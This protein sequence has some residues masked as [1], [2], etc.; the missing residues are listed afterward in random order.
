M[1]RNRSQP[2][3]FIL[4]A[5]ILATVSACCL[6][7]TGGLVYL[8][9]Q[10]DTDPE[11]YERMMA[12]T[13]GVRSE[14]AYT[15]TEADEA[16]VVAV[17]LD[18]AAV[19]DAQA[20]LLW[21]NEQW[22]GHIDL[23][24]LL[25][26]HS[27]ESAGGTNMGDSPGLASAM[28]NTN[29]NPDD[30]YAA[31]QNLLA[32]WKQ[33]NVRAL[34][35][36]AAEYIL[37]DH[38]DW[39]GHASAGELGAGGFIPTTAWRICQVALQTS[40]DPVV[41][42]CDFWNQRVMF[43]AMAYE[44][45]RMGYYPEATTE[46]RVNALYGWNHSESYR[47]QLVSTAD[48]YS[49]YGLSGFNLQTSMLFGSPGEYAFAKAMTI[50]FFQ[51]LGLL[52]EN[53]LAE[54]EQQTAGLPGG[55]LVPG[56]GQLTIDLTSDVPVADG[57]AYN[58]GLWSSLNSV[59]TVPAGGTWSFCQ[60]TNQTGWTEYKF[61]ANISAGGIC[62]NASVVKNWASQVP[63]LEV[64]SAPAHTF[65]PLYPIFTVGINCPGAD[66]VLKNTTDHDITARWSQSDN[67]LIFETVPAT[68]ASS[69]S[70][71]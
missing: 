57:Q 33:H 6:G 3:K 70:G 13:L 63:G 50:E 68:A 43:F 36:V 4:L 32:W 19:A 48:I 71:Q 26:V 14:L 21:I 5:L 65:Y 30:E 8:L 18:P 25:S 12:Q 67:T 69:E 60:Q 56:S 7:P 35:P 51:E 29:L 66:L 59:I 49:G 23:P 24:I 37:P 45:N 10:H 1:R 41:K 44:I 40:D 31:G 52:P 27:G 61:A 58:V 28:G 2:R 9:Y 38:S 42:S 11:G 20:A 46:E 15:L 16:E 39:I 22:A 55:T 34:N 17:G 53:W 54:L 62:A 64:V 47:R